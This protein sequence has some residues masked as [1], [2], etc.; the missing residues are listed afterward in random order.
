MPKLLSVSALKLRNLTLFLFSILPGVM[1]S[2]R[3]DVLES[4]RYISPDG[5]DW[6]VEGRILGTEGLV[7]PVLR[8]V[9][10]VLSSRLDWLLGGHGVVFALV[11][12]S[13]LFL[14]GISLIL[15]LDHF[16]VSLKLQ[17]IG[18]F[19]YFGS[20][21]H[22]SSMYVLPD[23]FAVGCLLFGTTLLLVNSSTSLNPTLISSVVFF[24]GSIFQF[25]AFAGFIFSIILAKSWPKDLSVK[26]FRIFI[27]ILASTA[28]ICTTV[29]WRQSI[30]HLSVPSQF[31]LLEV[32]LNMLP[33]YSEVWA[34]AFVVPLLALIGFAKLESI[35]RAIRSVHIRYFLFFGLC[36]LTMA[37]FYQW[38]DAR[39]AYSG[40]SFLLIALITLLLVSISPATGKTSSKGPRVS[41]SIWGV[42]VFIIALTVF[43]AP[44]D[45]WSPKLI[46]TRPLNTW[47]LLMVREFFLNDYSN[48]RDTATSISNSCRDLND[49]PRILDSINNSIYSPYEKT[50]LKIYTQYRVCN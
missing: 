30:P 19:L 5:L 49:K 15:F 26:I 17:T 35:R 48:Y 13:G 31:D 46:E 29:V 22:F 42:T 9:G 33:F 2:P 10:F 38:P 40:V 6:I 25:Y 24:I 47:S 14:Q 12:I 44:K 3:G 27:I 11:N 34:S 37:F 45:Y 18:I 1:I 7:L 8:N 32:S 28:S 4:H 20:W 41:E 50:I 16:K 39:I 36:F 21:I 43:L 23:T